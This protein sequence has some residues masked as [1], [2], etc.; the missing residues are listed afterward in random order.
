MDDDAII[1]KAFREAWILI[2]ADKD[3]GEKVYR[4]RQPHRGIVLMRL[5]NQLVRNKINVVAKLLENHRE[6][7]ADHYVVVSEKRVR[8]A[9]Q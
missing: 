2:T 3:F 6:A 5:D 7:L 8:F 4:E 1:R 9:S